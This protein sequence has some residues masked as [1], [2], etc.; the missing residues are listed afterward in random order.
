V[1]HRLGVQVWAGPGLRERSLDSFKRQWKP[2]NNFQKE[3]DM[4]LD[5][6]IFFF[7]WFN[8]KTNKQTYTLAALWR[9]D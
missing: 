4:I 2:L 5:F 8:L 3:S 7:F 1:T 6:W 9:M